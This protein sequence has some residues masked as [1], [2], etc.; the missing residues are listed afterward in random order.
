MLFAPIRRENGL[1]LSDADS[2]CG[3]LRGAYAPGSDR[4]LMVLC[5][6]AAQERVAKNRESWELRY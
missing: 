2:E 3:K 6:T 4:G 5:S 1:I